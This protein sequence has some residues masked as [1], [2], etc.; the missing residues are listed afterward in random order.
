MDLAI[1]TTVGLCTGTEKE[2]KLEKITQVH[3]N[4][5]TIEANGFY[6]RPSVPPLS[7]GSSS[8]L[9]SRQQWWVA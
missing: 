4:G 1:W 8:L 9:L 2:R 6:R 5:R 3:L 7:P